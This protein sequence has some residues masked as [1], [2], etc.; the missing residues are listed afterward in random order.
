[1]TSRPDATADTPVAALQ[2]TLAAE[3]AAVYGY[4]L[5]GGRLFA[6]AE[7]AASSAFAGHEARRDL[8]ARLIRDRS[9]NPGRGVAG[10]P[11]GHP[12]RRPLD[13]RC[14]SRC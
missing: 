5:V 7:G 14:D 12:G 2:D 1:M 13:R 9:A 8:V 6:T 3:H 4:G 11:T 10:V